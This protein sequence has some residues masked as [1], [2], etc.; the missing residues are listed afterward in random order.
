MKRKIILSILVVLL[1]VSGGTI[2]YYYWYQGT[3][4]VSSDDARIT[5]DQYKVM[6]QITAEIDHIDVEEGDVLKR[7]EPIAEQNVSGLDASVISKS[8]LRA[9]IDGTVIKVYSKQHEI[10]SPSA[11]VA[12]MA[13]MNNLY[14]STNIEETDINRIKPGELVDVTLDADGNHVIQGKVRKVGQASN[15]VFAM[16]A[17]TNTSGNFNKVTQRIPVEIALSVPQGM[18]L[19]PGTNVEVKI[20]TS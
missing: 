12:I 13:D 8:V 17:A 1:V 2:G 4:Y 10:A 14:V 16:I 7:N 19:I 15:S 11:A 6:P 9:P 5:A 3:H 18:T 20:H